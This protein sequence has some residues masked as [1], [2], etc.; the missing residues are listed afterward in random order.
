MHSNDI[1]KRQES[2]NVD[3][4]P[5]FE[6]LTP[7]PVPFRH[8]R[9][10]TYKDEILICGGYQNNQCYSYHT[11]KN[12]YKYIC[13]YPDGFPLRRHCVVKIV[14]GT[15]RKDSTLL[16]FGGYENEKKHAVVL[17]YKSVWNS[18]EKKEIGIERA[19]GYN[20]WLPF[21]DNDN[22]PICIGRDESNYEGVRA[23]IGGSNNH[24]LFIVYEP[25]N[26]DVFDLHTFQF[27]KQDILP[28]VSDVYY[29]CL[30]SKLKSE[31]AMM[32]TKKKKTEMVLLCNETGLAIDY[33][34]ENNAFQFNKLQLCTTIKTFHAYACVCVDDI[35]LIFG[36][37][38]GFSI[39]ISK[40]VYKYSIAKNKWMKFDCTLPIQLHECEGVL[41]EDN[42]SAYILGGCSID[43]GSPIHVK[44][45]VKQ[46]TKE[47]AT[48]KEKRWITEEEE[49]IEVEKIKAEL[50]EMEQELDIKKLKRFKEVKIIV[51]HWNRLL[52]IK[53]GWIDEFDIIISRYILMKYFK[54]VKA[55]S[56]HPN[57]INSVKFSPNGTKVISASNDKTIQVWDIE[58]GNKIQTLEGHLHFV[59]DAKFSPDGNIVVSGSEDKTIRLWDV[60]S[61][62]EIHKL[63]GHL[64]GVTCV[65]FSPDGGMI[66]SCSKD[67]TIRLWDA[68]SGEEREKLVIHSKRIKTV[69]F[70]P[71]GQSIVSSSLDTTIVTRNVKSS[72]RK[73]QLIG[74]LLL[75][76]S[77]QFSPDS[78]FLVG[79]SWDQIV[80]TWD[81][82]SGKVVHK[83][84]G[85]SDRIKGARYSTDGQTII[86]YSVDK[87]IRLWDIKLGLEIQKL[88]VAPKDYVT[89][90]DVSPDGNAIVSSSKNGKIQLWRSL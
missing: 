83:L 78:Q 70:S 88:K 50:E 44:T 3:T 73:H 68:K 48:E 33:S 79:Y 24:L 74:R 75:V 60:K 14:S 36:G 28:C 47:H 16:S 37:F 56:A 82:R 25:R 66:V 63:K 7:L 20:K 49:K 18:D 22:N 89:K 42:T 31:A 17:R 9:C 72:E 64:G 76:L 23:V 5:S 34:E 67:K 19:N 61:G 52:C 71:N 46:W 8:T 15:H 69:Q 30:I 12:E 45:N 54:P 1:T 51:E 84:K 55:I 32:Q 58:S 6:T 26:I 13:S 38:G 40:D 62:R 53:L 77:A 86:S 90:L 87:T 2:E 41:S 59:N 27:V 43:E 29:P 39:G 57:R 81:L 4:A 85:H 11:L 80:R 21:T 10:V 35:V 65:Q